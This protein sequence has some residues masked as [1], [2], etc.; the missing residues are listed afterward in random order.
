MSSPYIA[1]QLLAAVNADFTS[2][3]AAQYDSLVVT[4]VRHGEKKALQIH[5]PYTVIKGTK[6]L[7][8]S[9]YAVVTLHGGIGQPHENGRH[10]FMIFRTHTY[11][12]H[13]YLLKESQSNPKE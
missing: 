1:Q 13:R 2:M 7:L 8:H 11:H 3:T 6:N 9:F 4:M 10:T 12:F 5:N